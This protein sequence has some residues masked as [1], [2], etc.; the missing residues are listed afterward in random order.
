MEATL[1]VTSDALIALMLVARSEVNF[2]A[3][4]ERARP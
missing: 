1:S 3:I 4:V 2:S